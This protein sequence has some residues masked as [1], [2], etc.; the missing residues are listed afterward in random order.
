[1]ESNDGEKNDQLYDSLFVDREAIHQ[2]LGTALEWIKNP[3][4]RVNRIY[5]EPEGACGYRTPAHERQAGYE[6][7]ADAAYR[8]QQTLHA[9]RRESHLGCCAASRHVVTSSICSDYMTVG[10]QELKAHLSEYVRGAVGGENI[11]LT[12]GGKAVARLVSLVWHIDGRSGDRGRVDHARVAR[13]VNP[14]Y[15]LYGVAQH[16]GG[17]R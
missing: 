10:I 7:L 11:L 6:V 5:W 15:L 4:H 3:A 8:F 1:M 13:G 2:T 9:L 14:A 16:C 12:D 17:H